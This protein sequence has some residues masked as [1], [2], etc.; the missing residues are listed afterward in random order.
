[1]VLPHLIGGIAHAGGHVYKHMTTPTKMN[2]PMR[3]VKMPKHNE[4]NNRPHQNPHQ[5]PRHKPHQNPRHHKQHHEAHRK[6]HHHKQDQEQQQQQQQGQQKQKQKSKKLQQQHV[7]S[8][9]SKDSLAYIPGYTAPPISKVN[10]PNPLQKELQKKSINN[11]LQSLKNDYSP[12]ELNRM[13]SNLYDEE[14][15]PYQQTKRN[16]SFKNQMEVLS[17]KYGQ[18][19]L[20]KMIS[21]VDERYPHYLKLQK[22]INKQMDMGPTKKKKD[23]LSFINKQIEA[24]QRR[25]LL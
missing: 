6:H 8:Q 18:K 14:I 25:F 7:V 24:S 11:S 16:K 20:D 22:I 3:N 2:K 10:R 19:K 21:N 4:P 1:M 12:Q 15:V 13:I 5:T 17:N 23:E 9:I